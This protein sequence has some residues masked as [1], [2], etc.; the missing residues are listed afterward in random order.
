MGSVWLSL[1]G[2]LRRRWGALLALA[3]LLG[4]AG[5]VVLTAAAGADRTDTAYP[6]LLQW[7]RAAQVDLLPAGNRPV[8][9]YFAALGRLPQVAAM[10]T[11]VLYQAVL[12]PRRGAPLTPVETFASPD[13]AFGVSADRVKIVAG[14]I[15]NP[16]AAGQAMIDQRLAGLEHLRP[17]GTLHLLLIPSNPR[18]GNPEP[19]RASPIAFRVSA[20]VVFDSQVVPGTAANSEPTALLSTPFAGTAVAASANYGIQ[21][22][23]RLRPGASMAGFL[24]AASTL[25]SRD[26]AT[27]GRV[28]VLSTAD[29]VAAT[30]R[31]I[32]PEAVT[33]ALF[34]GLAGLIAL[35]VIAQLLGRQLILDSAEFPILRVLGMTR[36]RLVTLSLA[37]TAVI[38]VAGA[39]I[40]TGVAIAASP[41][42]PIGTARLAEPSPGIQVNFGVLAA[43]FAV[44]AILPLAALVPVAWRAAA[45]VQGPLGVAEPGSGARASQLGSALG[46]A[47]SVTGGIGVRM[48]LEPGHGRSAVPVRSALIGTTVAVASVVAAVIFGSSL[49][50]LV[51]TPHRY[52]QNWA[53][54]LDFG[55]GGLTGELSAKVLSKEP[56]VSGYAAGNYGQLSIGANKTIVPAIGIDLVR[57]QGFLTLLAG[58]APRRPDEIVLG[59]QTLRAVHARLGQR[60]RVVVNQVAARPSYGRPR[61]TMRIVGVAV[62]PLFSRG[63]FAATDLGTGAAV[64]APVLSEVSPQTRCAGRVTCYG[65]LLLRYRPGTDLAAAAARLT[66]VLLKKGCPPGSCTVTADRQQADIRDYAEVRDTPLLLGAVLALL[67]VGTLAHVLL[68]SVRRRRRDLAVLKAIGLLSSQLIRVVCWQASALAAV[69]LAVG[70][71]VGLVAGRWSWMLFARSVGVADRPDVPVLLVLI[72]IPV[73]LLLAG[74]I[75]AGPGWTAARIRPAQVL[76]AE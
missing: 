67:A 6:R 14:R 36:G 27:G 68:T 40:A 64:A 4:F 39:V 62:F 47:G 59:A 63:G 44:L 73:T 12:P 41:L 25:A 45:R 24:S 17:G 8:P 52:G 51:S 61:R 74:I 20:V 22:G 1:R 31:A 71:P 58:R 72:V 66:A 18:T 37:R 60:I 33:L 38:T 3:L 54:V 35:A 5:G 11:A 49:I 23:V 56:A 65:F 70:L 53:Q 55:F 28:I 48:A 7:A 34:A 32:R 43:G 57:G 16:R 69:A 50:G 46:L 42:M 10:S 76:R 30:Q 9:G 29:Q 2:E 75:A 21:G 13:R 26:P 15:F 19:K